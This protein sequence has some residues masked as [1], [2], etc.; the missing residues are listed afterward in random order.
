M[1]FTSLNL[2]SGKLGQSIELRKTFSRLTFYC[3][4][5]MQGKK[6]EDILQQMELTKDE[7]EYLLSTM[8]QISQL[9]DFD[10]N[11]LVA[12]ISEECFIGGTMIVKDKKVLL[13]L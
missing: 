13:R 9:K 4:L 10:A 8:V 5:I 1:D 11:V 7:W 2:Q 3:D 12:G 6:H